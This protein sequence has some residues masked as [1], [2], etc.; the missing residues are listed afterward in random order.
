MP[1]RSYGRRCADNLEFRCKLVLLLNLTQPIVNHARTYHERIVLLN[2]DMVQKGSAGRHG[3]AVISP[4][5]IVFQQ[6]P[7]IAAGEALRFRMLPDQTHPVSLRHFEIRTAEQGHQMFVSVLLCKTRNQAVH[8]R[9]TD[10]VFAPLRVDRE[11][12]GVFPTSA[13]RL[14]ICKRSVSLEDRI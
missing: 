1:V 12:P 11:F 13:V 5:C 9:H 3:S 14:F 2:R 4:F 6:I 10:T 7:E 8:Q